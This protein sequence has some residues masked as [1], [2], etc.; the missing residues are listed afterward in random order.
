MHRAGVLRYDTRALHVHSHND[1]ERILWVMV[2]MRLVQQLISCTHT[3]TAHP[4]TFATGNVFGR[5]R[6]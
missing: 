1:F 2:T 3:H 4:F 6:H 5:R